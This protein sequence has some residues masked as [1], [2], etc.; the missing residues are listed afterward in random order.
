LIKERMSGARRKKI[1]DLELGEIRACEA[2]IL[3]LNYLI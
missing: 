2:T 3:P 1:K